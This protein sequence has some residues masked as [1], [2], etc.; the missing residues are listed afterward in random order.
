MT[1]I[2]ERLKDIRKTHGQTLAEFGKAIGYHL[3]TVSQVER[4][5]PP[6]NNKIDDRYILAVSRAYNVSEQWIRTGEGEV[7]ASV[8]AADAEA[9]RAQMVVE[10]YRE[11]S[12]K[13]QAMIINLA[14][15]LIAEEEAKRKAANDGGHGDSASPNEGA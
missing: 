11:L 12:P 6:Y 5:V 8:P 4:A 3:S 7:Q 9:L 10:M 14:K 15:A 1:T 2:N 13:S